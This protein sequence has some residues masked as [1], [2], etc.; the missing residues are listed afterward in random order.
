MCTSLYLPSYISFFTCNVPRLAA[1]GGDA[2]DDYEPE[3][4]GTVLPFSTA[5]GQCVCNLRKNFHFVKFAKYTPLENNSLYG[6][7]MHVS[8]P[9]TAAAVQRLCGHLA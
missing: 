3:S 7:S 2:D 4:C 5:D 9:T 1:A 8:L 6:K